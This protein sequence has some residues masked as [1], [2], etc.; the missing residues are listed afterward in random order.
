MPL[1]NRAD[2]HARFEPTTGCV[3]WH[4]IAAANVSKIER[5]GDLQTLKQFL[6]EIAVGRVD[7]DDVDANIGLAK[8]F[9]LAQLQTQYVLHCQQ[10]GWAGHSYRFNSCLGS[11]CVGR[12][13]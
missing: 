9:R 2:L 8:A 10:V 6:P 7:E 5:D 12:R 4:Q 13:C 3:E 11:V 1:C